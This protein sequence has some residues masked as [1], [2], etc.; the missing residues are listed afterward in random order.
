MLS[1]NSCTSVATAIAST[2][3]SSNPVLI[4]G[5]LLARAYAILGR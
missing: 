2:R 1:A 4:S 5:M 3:R